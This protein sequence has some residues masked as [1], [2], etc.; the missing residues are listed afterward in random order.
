MA[1][2]LKKSGAAASELPPRFHNFPQVLYNVR[3]S[4][5]GWKENDEV[6]RKVSEAEQLLGTHGRVLVRPSGT[7]P[8]LRV[9][10]E[11]RDSDALERVADELIGTVTRALG[12]EVQGKV[13][14]ANALGD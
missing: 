8:V 1:R 4:N 5:I 13:D 11:S 7:Q 14:L 6:Q 2:V 9:M 3:V 12:G 10:V